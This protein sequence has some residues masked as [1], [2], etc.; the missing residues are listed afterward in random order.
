[1]WQPTTAAVAAGH[2]RSLAD[3]AAAEAMRRRGSDRAGK[4]LTN[5]DLPPEALA[6]AGGAK[7]GGAVPPGTRAQGRAAGTQPVK[8]QTYWRARVAPF[9][10]RVRE[11]IVK[12]WI[13]GAGSTT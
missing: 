7:T 2:P 5:A 13:S 3:L 8:D 1:M 12:A 6:P 10:L 11:N 4:V 9:N